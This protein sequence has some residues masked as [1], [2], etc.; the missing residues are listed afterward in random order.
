MNSFDLLKIKA[1]FKKSLGDF[2]SDWQRFLKV[3][4]AFFQTRLQ[5]LLVLVS[6][7]KSIIASLL[8]RQRGRFAQ[9]FTHFLLGLILF[10]G[11]SFSSA[12]EEKIRGQQM[13][14]SAGE[15]EA[16]AFMSEEQFN[17]A[18]SVS[19]GMRGEVVEYAVKS[20]DTVS[21]IAKTFGVSVDTIIWANKLKS[22]KNIK[23]GQ[24]LKIPPVTG[25]VHK[26]RRG[27]TVY[28]I[29]KKYSANP[30]EI[31][32]YPFNTFANDETF[33]LQI[34]QV[35]YVP[36]GVMPKARPRVPAPVAS[37]V[38]RGVGK[39]MF[40][41]PTSGRITQRYSWYHPAV[42][43]ANKSAPDV[44]AAASGKVI[45]VI[46]SRWGYGRH[47]VI[48]HGNGYRTLYAH[49]NRIYVK[50]GQTVSQGQALGQMGSTGRS[51]GTHL[52][53]EII[54]KGTKL[55]PLSLLK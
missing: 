28:S 1:Q 40:I 20:G 19:G 6:T 47:V 26:V 42:D 33:A 14:W 24:R 49:L 52:H 41:W 39:G 25:I 43:I 12:L 36:N 21:S 48:D 2:S 32:D 3:Y 7:V 16:V 27:E 8:Y 51:T 34:G 29:A 35:L 38:A 30:Q 23:V 18:T 31:V 46:S 13:D 54:K 17:A 55:N 4:A 9:P 45:L 11:I 53:F 5:R 10:L 22:A 44:V 50:K 15:G 37:M